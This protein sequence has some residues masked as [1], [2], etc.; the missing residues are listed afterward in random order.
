MDSND[1]KIMNA[2]LEVF[3]EKSYG[4]A[5]TKAIAKKAGFSELTLFRKFKNKESLFKLVYQKNLSLFKNQVKQANQEMMKTD[6]PDTHSFMKTL[7]DKYIKI[8]DT[9]IELIRITVLDTS[10]EG[11]PFED[12]SAQTAQLLEVKI[13]NKKIEF[14]SF[15][16]IITGSLIMLGNNKYLGR[17]AIDH[18]SFVD[19]LANN[20]NQCVRG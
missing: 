11:E 3:A 20:F 9:N 19:V 13:P 4:G 10:I 12:I 14:L 18:D 16:L 2:A 8:I 6:F 5:T 15:G 1:E 7:I 17:T